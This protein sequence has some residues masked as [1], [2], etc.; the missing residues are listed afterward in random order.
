MSMKFNHKY[1]WKLFVV[2]NLTLYTASQSLKVASTL[3]WIL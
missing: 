1:A 2:F 3:I